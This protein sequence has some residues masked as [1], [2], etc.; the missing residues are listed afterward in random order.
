MQSNSHELFKQI[1]HIFMSNTLL[2]VSAYANNFPYL[3][4][5]DCINKLQL[6]LCEKYACLAPVRNINLLMLLKRFMINFQTDLQ[7]FSNI[8]VSRY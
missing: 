3:S 7:Y 5:N 4:G 6:Y 2:L 1:L 8:P